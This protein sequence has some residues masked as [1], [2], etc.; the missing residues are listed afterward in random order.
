M[1]NYKKENLIRKNKRLVKELIN[2]Y[3]KGVQISFQ[4]YNNDKCLDAEFIYR[5][6]YYSIF[7]ESV[8]IKVSQNLNEYFDKNFSCVSNYDYFNDENRVDK[9]IY[10]KLGKSRKK[11][12]YVVSNS[13]NNKNFKLFQEFLDFKNNNLKFLTS[14]CFPMQIKCGL[15]KNTWEEYGSFIHIVLPNVEKLNVEDLINIITQGS[16]NN[17][18]VEVLYKDYWKQKV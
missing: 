5:N 12:S 7:V 4:L 13:V 16:I 14:N 3:G 1:K 17:K 15:I 10:K 2:L 8:H 11:V 18:T 6:K 9:V